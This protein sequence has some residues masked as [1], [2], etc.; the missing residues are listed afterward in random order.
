MARLSRAKNTIDH[1]SEVLQLAANTTIRYEFCE[2][3]VVLR[4]Q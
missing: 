3:E 4:Q 1:S 2:A